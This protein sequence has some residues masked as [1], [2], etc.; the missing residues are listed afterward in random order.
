MVNIKGIILS[1]MHKEGD[2]M[3]NLIKQN[4]NENSEYNNKLEAF[5]ELDKMDFDIKKDIDYKDEIYNG[6]YNKYE[7]IN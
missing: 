1:E 3:K 4:K 7:N 5:N 6:I 2:I